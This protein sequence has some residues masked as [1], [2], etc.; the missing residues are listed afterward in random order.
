[1]LYIGYEEDLLL[2]VQLSVHIIQL[3]FFSVLTLSTLPYND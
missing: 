2:K 1:M 3:V